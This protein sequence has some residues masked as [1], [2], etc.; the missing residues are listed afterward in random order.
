MKCPNCQK[1]I[2]DTEISHY[3]ASKGGKTASKMSKTKLK[4]RAKKAA[5]ARWGNKG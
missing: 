3:L 4:A 1:E 5:L 2:S